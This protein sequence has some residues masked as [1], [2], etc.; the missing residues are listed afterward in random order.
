MLAPFVAMDRI[1]V[2]G[3]DD[4][5]NQQA[6]TYAEYRVFAVVARHTRSIRRVRVV[7]SPTTA[8]KGCDRVACAVTVDLEPAGSFR[9][10][11]VG[12]HAYAAINGAVERLGA[13]M[14]R[15]LDRRLSS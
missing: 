5:V 14:G 3:G 9:I 7:I 10:R 6:R 2:I 11:A 13:V 12:S 4:S 8:T 1:L 15:R